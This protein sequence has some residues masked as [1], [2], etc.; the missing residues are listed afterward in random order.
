MFHAN[1]KFYYFC[2]KDI[3]L[4]VT[5]VIKDNH[6]NNLITKFIGLGDDKIKCIPKQ[7]MPTTLT[8]VLRIED[9]ATKPPIVDYYIMQLQSSISI[10]LWTIKHNLQTYNQ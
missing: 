3:Y 9:D 6:I 7:P 1:W 10:H 8:Q 5:H 2:I 4:W